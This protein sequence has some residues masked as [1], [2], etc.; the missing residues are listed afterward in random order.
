MGTKVNSQ[1][2]LVH[3]PREITKRKLGQKTMELGQ[4][5]ASLGKFGQCQAGLE[6]LSKLG[7]VWTSL[8]YAKMA[9]S[10]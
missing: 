2:A 7:L 6:S 4:I 1:Q 9:K 10:K 5:W 8:D 3:W